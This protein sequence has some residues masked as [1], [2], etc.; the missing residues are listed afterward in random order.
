M[1]AIALWDIDQEKLML[2]R[3]PIGKKPIHYFVDKDKAIFA[4]SDLRQPILRPLGFGSIFG[5]W[6]GQGA[7]GARTVLYFGD[8]F[9]FFIFFFCP[10]NVVIPT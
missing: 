1:F 4:S 10:L 9:K 6:L 5:A 7:F 3:D 8:A 2:A